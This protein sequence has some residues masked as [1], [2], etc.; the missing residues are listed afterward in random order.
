MTTALTHQPEFGP[1]QM[2]LI[3]EK[4]APKADDADL[5]LFAAL[6]QRTGLDP[7][8]NQIYLVGRW[9][10]RLQKEVYR[11]Q[12][13]IDGL[14][15]IAQRSGEIDGQDGPYW[16]G[17]D[18][19]W[20]DVWLSPDRPSAAKVTVFRKGCRAGFT[21]VATL[22]EYMQTGKDGKP[23]G[24]WG[25]MPSVMLAKCA[26][27]LAIRKAFPQEL[28]GLYE[29]SELPESDQ[30]EVVE[31]RT[32]RP[33]TPAPV[34]DP[35]E[36]EPERGEAWEDPADLNKMRERL[37]TAI[38]SN[39]HELGLDGNDPRTMKA[40]NYNRQHPLTALSQIN[41]LP[42]ADLENLSG[43]LSRRLEQQR[44]EASTDG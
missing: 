37:L 41:S 11:P 15:L 6:C 40:I 14:R 19:A 42:L 12:V 9:D 21:G 1:D 33:Q 30:V 17:P 7:F 39:L 16:C 31:V 32:V 29:P 38:L 10:S 24:L 26:E 18:G 4:L 44:K 8:R 20:R 23:S 22:T 5:S 43:R 2:R 34:P 13:S 27:S 3:R 36:I 25:K 35:A 28:S